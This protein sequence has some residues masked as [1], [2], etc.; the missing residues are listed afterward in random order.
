MVGAGVDTGIILLA[1]GGLTVQLA[2][3]AGHHL[4]E[5]TARKIVLTIASGAGMFLAGTKLAQTTL[6]GAAAIFTTGASL[7]VSGGINAGLNMV[8][9]H[10]YGCSA[11]RVF[12]QTTEISDV[13]VLVR[14]VMAI[15]A[16]DFGLGDHTNNLIS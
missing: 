11:A 13:D 9:T 4:S 12:M 8:L 2:K 5:Q 16:A 10:A 3:M 7:P 15:M 14:S 1:W 6:D